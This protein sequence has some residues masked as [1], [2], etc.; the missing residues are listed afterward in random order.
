MAHGDT[1][2]GERLLRKL[3][4]QDSN[5]ELLRVFNNRSAVKSETYTLSMERIIELKPSGIHTCHYLGIRK[6]FILF[7]W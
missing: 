4:P 2:Y 6:S 7:R 1:F 5:T 3:S